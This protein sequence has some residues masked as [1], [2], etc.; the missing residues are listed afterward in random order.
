MTPTDGSE[1]F[2]L[3]RVSDL[4]PDQYITRFFNTG[5]ERIGEYGE[6]AS[7]GPDLAT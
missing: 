1:V 3:V 2:S 4:Y 6:Q 5:A 7:R